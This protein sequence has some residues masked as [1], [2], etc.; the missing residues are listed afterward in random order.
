MQAN[1]ASSAHWPGL[2]PLIPREVLFGNPERMNPQLSPD[3]EH[4][5]WVAPD[6][7][8]VLQVWVQTVG[9]EDIRALTADRKRGVREYFWCEDNKTMIYLQDADGDE[10][11]HLYGVDVATGVVRDL[12]PF[13][14][15][16]AQPL[17]QDRRF[18]DQLLLTMNLRNRELHDVYRLTLS[19]GELELDTE[20]PGA[21]M[22]FVAD[23]HFQV[24][25][26]FSMSMDGGSELLVRD[27]VESPWRLW[28]RGGPDETL[29]PH[30]F[31]ADGQRVILSTSLG[32]DTA[33]LVEKD[34]STGEERLLAHSTEVDVGSVMID[35]LNHHVQAVAF[36]PERTSWQVLDEAIAED[37]AGIQR[38][39][40]G[41]FAII[42]RD[43]EDHNWLVA[44]TSDR[45]PISYFQWSRQEKRGRFLFV[46]QP[47][48]QGLTLGEMRP[49]RF[50]ARDGLTLHGYLTLPPGVEPKGLPMV[51]LVH[52]GPWVRD[53]WGYHAQAQWFA[54]RGYACL[55][56]N[57]R[58]STGYG[59]KFLGAG[60]KQWGRAMHDDLIDSVSWA[61]DQGLVDPARVAIYG[62]SYGGYS[63]LAG[64]T[65]TPAFFACSVAI[66]GPSN[67]RTF[68]NSIPPYW[69]AFRGL[70]DARVGN[71]DDPVEAEALR[72]VSPITYVDR[73]VKPLLI[74]QGANDPRVVANESEQIVEAIQHNQGSV[75]Y[76]LYPD[77]GHGFIRP[78]NRLDFNV[79]AELFLA[80]HL[81]GRAEDFPG[82]LKRVEGSSALLKRIVCGEVVE[83]TVQKT[84]PPRS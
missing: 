37:M 70:L 43:R 21:G 74:G 62:G 20:N 39:H 40:P 6:E 58:S 2:P 25:L 75:T 1:V 42:N 54:N 10:N 11:W 24:R 5:A 26:V 18:P 80:Q 67:L 34:I 60:Y 52:G 15:V 73:I 41:D 59:K 81:G 72:E 49:V 4:I 16:Q 46:Q 47:R 61:V 45:G 22:A 7:K 53:V 8:G 84:S 31:T 79:R 56:V 51:L 35:P 27:R 68:I 30:G 33:R 3:G 19:T 17:E 13:D 12:T 44:F 77:E 23:E 65:F 69:R 71:V 50:P 55:Q 36:S 48:L 9:G 57:Y 66:V 38:L 78:E 14:G 28:L 76:V 29:S 63:A 64:V 82:H 32:G 83:D